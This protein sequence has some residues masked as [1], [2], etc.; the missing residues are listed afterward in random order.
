MK[1]KNIIRIVVGTALILMVPLVAMQ[2]TDEVQWELTDFIIIG[3]LLIGAGLLFELIVAKVDVKYRIVVGALIAMA[4]LLI[5]AE[6][7]VGIFG[8]PFGGS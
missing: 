2:F 6:L 3:A 4:V 1:A 8:T 5:W 7:A